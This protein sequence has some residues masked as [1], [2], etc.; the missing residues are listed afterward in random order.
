MLG[1]LENLFLILFCVNLQIFKA[2]ENLIGFIYFLKVRFN[3]VSYISSL[4]LGTRSKPQLI[5]E[6]Q[7]FAQKAG[8][9]VLQHTLLPR[10][11]AF[12]LARNELKDTLEY[13]YDVTIAYDQ[14]RYVFVMFLI[15]LR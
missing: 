11:G 2:L 14:T 5:D 3:H 10:V 4:I 1:D 9:P 6:S 15:Y 7:R 12:A 13:V 8:L